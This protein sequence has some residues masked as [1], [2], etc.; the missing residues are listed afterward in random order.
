MLVDITGVVLTPGNNG[1]DCMGNGEHYDGNGNQIICCDE[2][3]YQL[4]CCE[5]PD[6]AKCNDMQCPR[7]EKEV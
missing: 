1:D 3:S 2:C 6:C 5:K 7:K 4:C